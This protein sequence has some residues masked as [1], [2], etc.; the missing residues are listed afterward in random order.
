MGKQRLTQ[1]ALLFLIFLLNSCS[2]APYSSTTSGRSYGAGKVQAEVGNINSTYNLKFGL[3]VTKDFDFGFV[4]EF[5]AISTS[6]LFM[7]YSFINNETGPSLSGEFGYGSTETTKF[8]YLGTT[9]SLAFS[10]E[11]E[12]F[13]NAR[14]NSVSTDSSDIEKDEF[15]GNVKILAY[16]L[17][18]MQATM[19]F[20]LWFTEN[21]G[22]SL[23]STYYKGED[24]ETLSDSTFGG[25]L[26]FNF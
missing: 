8:Y 20:N 17:T 14:I 19:G 18:Y 9:G 21:A 10:K 26:L 23:Y 1:C 3:G 12:L 24:I 6:A 11:F 25:S 15:N 2:L 7:K 13:L 22:L 16:D 4:M 5:G